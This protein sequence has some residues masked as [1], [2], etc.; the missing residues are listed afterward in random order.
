MPRKS[1]N[2]GDTF[3]F[4]EGLP[5]RVVAFLSLA[6]LPIGLLAM[7]QTKSLDE[8]LKARTELSLIALTELASSGERRTLLQALGTA[9]AQAAILP[10]L[11]GERTQEICDDIFGDLVRAS[12]QYS[13]VGFLP[14]EGSISCSSETGPIAPDMV[15]S[16][17]LALV[18]SPDLTLL[19]IGS[20]LS[21]G[22]DLAVLLQPVKRA[23][24]VIGQV[25]AA[26]P[27][28]VL[29]DAPDMMIERSP[30]SLTI[31]NQ[32]GEIITSS[33]ES[34]SEETLAQIRSVPVDENIYSSQRRVIPGRNAAGERRQMAQ[35][36]VVP[37]VAYAVASWPSARDL[38]GADNVLPSS[39]LPA[40]MW[41]ASLFVAYFA[42]HRL[43]VG[44]IQTMR[45]RMRLFAADRSLFETPEAGRLPRELYE[46]DQ[47]FN[48]MA[49]DLMDDEAR[50]E[51][52]LR[53]KNVLLKEIHH[54][55]KNNLQMV[56][57]I[58]SMQIRAT[59]QAA[60]ARTLERLR[61]RV[62]NLATV[63]RFLYMATNVGR[64][65]APPLIREICENLFA[66][67][68]LTYPTLKTS[69]DVDAVE[70]VPD[71]SVPLGLLIGE[72]IGQWQ[73]NISDEPGG[74]PVIAI[75]LR[76]TA[77]GTLQLWVR[78]S[79]VPEQQGSGDTV[80]SDQLMRAFALQLGGDLQRV[81][82]D[83][84]LATGLE[85]TMTTSIPDAMD[86]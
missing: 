17:V 58:I 38:D 23:E 60:A 4:L 11:E 18:D 51:D 54:R 16:R 9:E 68:E 34:L 73:R 74:R 19:R 29:S 61:D 15:D 50:M 79:P 78:S 28:E 13:F 55:V 44:P 45:R 77:P 85:F 5:F 10:N 70:L 32:G 57:S 52:S 24:T 35:V 7:W 14:A 22:T 42:V 40:L 43:V 83:E 64:I 86:Y 84:G 36:T 33:G 30:L 31:L 65:D 46:L 82:S 25:T 56:S 27:I 6:L 49:L 62:L 26:I 48:N 3:D 47:T 21:P 59:D 72:I 67:I 20:R 75:S 63:H 2:E 80:V 39:T 66:Q 12:D 81:K 76:V 71:Q 1:S 37:G 8:T 53:E 41:L 69:V